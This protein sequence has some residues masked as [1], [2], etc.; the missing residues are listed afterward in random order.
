V[1]KHIYIHYLVE[2][3]K[4]DEIIRL[5]LHCLPYGILPESFCMKIYHKEAVVWKNVRL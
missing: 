3:D 2:Y 4:H 5:H 1:D